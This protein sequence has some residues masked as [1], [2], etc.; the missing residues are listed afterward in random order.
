MT[1]EIS[2]SEAGTIESRDL[3]GRA[4]IATFVRGFYGMVAQDD[5]LSPMFEQV[6]QVDWGTHIDKLTDFWC[7]SLLHQAGY[8]GNPYSKHGAVHDRSPMSAAHF[9]RWLDLF[10]E[11]ISP[12]QGPK[13]D[14][15]KGVV[16]KVAEVHCY[17]ITGEQ[18][19]Y[20]PDESEPKRDIPLRADPQP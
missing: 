17:Q 5:L 14:H 20:G 8:S 1:T 9:D 16:V 15:A 4:E 18:Y 19:R 11:A 3:T 7:R 13:V 6:A 12:W 10:H 2:Q